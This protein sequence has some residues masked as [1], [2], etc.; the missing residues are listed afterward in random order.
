MATLQKR[1]D[2]WRVIFSFQRQQHAITLGRV[3]SSEAVQWQGKVDHILMRLKQRLLDLPTG[4][5]I[6]DGRTY[7]FGDGQKPLT[8]NHAKLTFKRMLKKSK[9]SVIR[10]WHCI[11]HCFISACA[12][13]NIDSRMLQSWVGHQTVAMTAR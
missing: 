10:G 4:T 9:W 11:R 8:V 13:R 2:S 5:R 6:A 1:G 3:P 7:L 12:V